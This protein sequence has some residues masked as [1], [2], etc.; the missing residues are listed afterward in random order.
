MRLRFAA[1]GAVMLIAACGRPPADDL[2][3]EF[4]KSGDEVVVTADLSLPVS[5][6]NPSAQQRVE[7]ARSAAAASTDPWTVRFARL[8]PNADFTTLHRDHGVLDHVTRS[9]TIAP[10]D[11]Q[12]V[13]S[14][15]NITVKTMR[16]DGWRELAFY[17][18]SSTRAT[19]EQQR[20]FD[21]ELAAWSRDVAEY[22][23]AVHQLYSY[24]DRQPH[25][26]KWLFAAIL[27]ERNEDG[28]DPVV[29]EEEQVL[30]DAVTNAMA[31]IADRMDAREGVA[32]TID[33][34]ADL[35]FNPFPAR[36][37]VRTPGTVLGS[38][39]FEALKGKDLVI[40]P[41][42]L[43]TMIHSLEGKWI[44]PDPLAAL[45]RDEQVTAAQIGFAKRTSTPVVSELEIANE[46]RARLERPKAYV[47]RWR[48]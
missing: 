12:L 36:I 34:E 46:V 29:L 13:F 15:A 3:I 8:R 21:A 48:E 7:S 2:T 31:N 32:E 17:P 42:D 41:I 14:D 23:R 44:S 35:I 28:S 11:L 43:Y 40:E 39:G 22:F 37:V 33:E 45:L 27:S 47:V 5:T 26:S 4:S 16:G 10:D 18:G 6:Q 25:R 24:L 9:V 38:E 19:R 20:E 30:V 1:L